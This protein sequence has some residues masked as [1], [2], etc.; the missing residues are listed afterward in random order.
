MNTLTILPRLLQS[1]SNYRN[2]ILTHTLSHRRRYRAHYTSFLRK[3]RPTLIVD[4]FL[5][6]SP[7]IRADFADTKR[8][9]WPSSFRYA[10]CN[11][12]AKGYIVSGCARLKYKLELFIEVLGSFR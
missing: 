12:D 1:E 2:R 3:S 10:C 8:I 11:E 4:K 6:R 7:N 9:I 5:C